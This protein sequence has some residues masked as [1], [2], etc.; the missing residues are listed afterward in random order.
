MLKRILQQHQPFQPVVLFDP[1]KDKLL[2]MDFTAA[3]TTLTPAIMNDTELFTDHILEQLYA[4]KCLFGIGGYAENRT[5]YAGNEHFNTADEPRS[6]HLAV[7]IWGAAGTVVYAPLDGEIHSFRFNYQ[8]GDYGATI[9]LRHQLSGY[10]FHTLYGHLSLADL[11]DLKVNDKIAAGQM[12]GHFGSNHENGHWPPHLHFQ[13]ITDMEGRKGDYPGV[14]K[15]S[16]REKY[17][18]NCPDPNI[19][20]QM[21]S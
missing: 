2:P 8:H 14:C 21:I 5:I 1:A 11:N 13:I 17:L 3:N 20:L 4:N 15:Y 6:L 18:S 7:D 10:T 9:I 19:I 12:L 16:E